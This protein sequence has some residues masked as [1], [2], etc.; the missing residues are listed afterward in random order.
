MAMIPEDKDY[1]D[2]K[3]KVKKYLRVESVSDNGWIISLFLLFFPV[4]AVLVVSAMLNFTLDPSVSLSLVGL[5][6]VLIYLVVRWRNKQLGQYQVD[7]R[8]WLNYYAYPACTNLQKYLFK[9]EAPGMKE[10]FRKNAIKSLKELADA[11]ARRWTVGDFSLVKDA[12]GTA[13]SDLTDIL[14]LWAIPTLEKEDEK[15]MMNLD[16]FVTS[17][18]W[19]SKT[20]SLEELK[21]INSRFKRNIVPSKK[22]EK[23][24]WDKFKPYKRLA[25]PVAVIVLIYAASVYYLMTS[26]K[27]DITASSTAVGTPVLVILAVIALFRGKTERKED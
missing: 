23:G 21:N 11:I 24:L 25:V 14:N 16:S 5:G 1:A 26:W 18:Y 17:L 22:K 8:E 9:D 19:L 13:V 10:D 3:V 27:W 6:F 2:L 4:M 12:V 7:S 20:L 15:K